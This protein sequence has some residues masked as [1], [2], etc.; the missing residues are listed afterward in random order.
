VRNVRDIPEPRTRAAPPRRTLAVS[1]AGDWLAEHPESGQTFDEY[2][3]SRPVR[4]S[5]TLHTIYLCLTVMSSEAVRA[6]LPLP[7][8]PAGEVAGLGDEAA[9][10]EPPAPG[11]SP[12]DEGLEQLK[13]VLPHPEGGPA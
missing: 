4:K 8:C 10:A 12:L 6:E 1:S 13:S 5:D 9:S 7:V 3:H 11:A 2:L